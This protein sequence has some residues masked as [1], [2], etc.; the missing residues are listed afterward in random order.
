LAQPQRPKGRAGVVPCGQAQWRRSSL[1][2]FRFRANSSR[3]I[4]GRLG[5]DLDERI[6]H[7]AGHTPQLGGVVQADEGGGPDGG[8]PGLP[9]LLVHRDPARQCRGDLEIGL[10]NPLGLMRVADLEDPALRA[11]DTPF[12]AILAL[13]SCTPRTPNPWCATA[14]SRSMMRR[15]NGFVDS[16]MCSITALLDCA[17]QDRNELGA[18]LRA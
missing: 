2:T 1:N 11:N 18:P 5:H 6:L 4:S 3:L 17:E 10:E 12:S 9:S 15:A 8:E 13:R 7:L 16:T 14:C